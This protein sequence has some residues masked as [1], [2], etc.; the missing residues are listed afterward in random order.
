MGSSILHAHSKFNTHVLGDID[1]RIPGIAVLGDDPT[2]AGK[3][4]DE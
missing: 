2:S 1:L 4:M 3:R